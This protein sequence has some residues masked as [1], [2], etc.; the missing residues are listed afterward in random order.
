MLLFGTKIIDYDSAWI[1][2]EDAL[3]GGIRGLRCPFCDTSLI[4]QKKN[5]GQA[6]LF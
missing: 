6:R 2:V 3:Q 4:A 5:K 1:F